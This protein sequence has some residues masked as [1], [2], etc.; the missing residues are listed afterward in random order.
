MRIPVL[1]V[2]VTRVHNN[3][4]PCDSND[5][6]A[7]SAVVESSMSKLLTPNIS[8]WGR[9]VRALWG[10][11]LIAAAFLSPSASTT[12]RV[13]LVVAAAFAFFEALQGWCVMRA[14]GIKTR[15]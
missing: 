5:L 12:L 4:C 2:S 11:A 13:V 8:G 9:I 6:P 7:P 3:T 10:V 14:C 1:P 15:I